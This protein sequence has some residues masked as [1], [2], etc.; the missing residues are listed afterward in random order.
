MFLQISNLYFSYPSSNCVLF[1]DFSVSIQEE[2]TV[3]AG[4]NGTGKSTLLK[5]IS[6]LLEADSG[7][8]SFSG[9]AFYCPQE[10]YDIPDNLYNAFWSQD[11]ETR[12]FF[13]MLHVSE[14]MLERYDTLSGGEKKRI[15]IA[16]A[17]AEKPSVLLLDEPTNHLDKETS[18]LIL[19]TLKTFSGIGIVVSHN[20]SFSDSLCTRT[21][22]LF[23]EAEN[24]S[25]GK[26]CVAFQDYPCSLS[27]AL[28]LRKSNAASSNAE[29]EKLNSKAAS[30]KRKAQKLQEEIARSKSRLSKKSFDHNDHDTQA[31]IDLA[32]ISGK[33]RSQG[34]AKAHLA[35]QL[36]RTQQQRDS[37]S[38]ALKRKEGF[39]VSGTDF[40]KPINIE[41]T[42]LKAGS[43]TI[44]IPRLEIKP[45][46]KF[47]LT[48]INGSGKTLF[49][50]H[51]ISILQKSGRIQEV[52]YLPQEISPDMQNQILSEFK[53]LDEA[54]KGEVLS[55]L[56][57]LGSS[58]KNFSQETLAAS[59]GELR[60]LMIAISICKPLS[61]LILDEPTNHM[62]I[63]STI[64][65][66][67]AL[68]QVECAMLIVS[69]DSSFL[70]KICTKQLCTERSGNN[71]KLM[72][73]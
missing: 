19:N 10:A 45:R 39:S 44:E 67:D 33:D 6:G 9:E 60:K 5:L 46:E 11:N 70:E 18:Q 36:S 68:S 27:K 31:K 55:T 15:Q 72:S 4:S 30:E 3:I 35:T 8:I 59:P 25:G 53:S 56:Y 51:V 29:W 42:C 20:R 37:I 65:L 64:A 40:S 17:L 69:H 66:E 71:G 7:K 1:E 14:D 22:Y 13:S 38:R 26:N 50:S 62:D 47:S 57:R 41:E 23:N 54:Q 63:T 34:D 28:E 48:G 24:F 73:L 58:P 49:I 52:M 21:I 43:Y 12:K 16:C 61:L 2:W 32:R